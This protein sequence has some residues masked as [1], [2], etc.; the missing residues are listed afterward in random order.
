MQEET[1]SDFVHLS[2]FGKGEGFAD[3]ATQ[4]LAQCGSEALD[5]VRGAFRVSGPVLVGG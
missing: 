2:G 5:M 1:D 3:E 4:A